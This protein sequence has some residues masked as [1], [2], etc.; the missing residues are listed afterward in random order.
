MRPSPLVLLLAALILLLV[1][2]TALSVRPPTGGLP[3]LSVQSSEPGGGR[4]LALWLEALGYRVDELDTEPYAVDPGVGALFVL[5][6]QTPFDEAAVD[7]VAAWVEGGGRLV[8]VTV[9]GQRALLERFGLRVRFAGD[10]LAEATTAQPLL[11]Q[12]PVERI[13]VDTWDFVEGQDG[14]APWLVAGDRVVLGSRPYG[15][16]QVIVLTALRP[17]SN[18]GLAEPESAALALNLVG[19]IPPG[20][21]VAFDEYHHGFVRGST[22]GLWQ[23]LLANYWGWAVIYAVALSYLYLWLRGRRF[24]P[25][26]GATTAARRSVSEYVASL[27]ALY[28]RAGQRGYVADRL[29]DQLKRDL[30]TGLGLNARLPDEA[31]AQ[32]VA[33][34]RATTPAAL[35][36]AFARLRAGG[37]LAERDLLALV[38]ETDALRA[39]LLRRAG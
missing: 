20:A 6:P 11:G 9:G 14:L 36:D 23:L 8:L 16:G 29:A 2:L 27:G 30:A 26:L 3:P 4:V 15:Q 32:A 13:R 25:P 12:P 1:I 21:R 39:R 7:A 17:L 34:R 5:A 10:R 33:D 35:A 38:R 19:R 18:E 31:F 22:R 28:R 37:R 24:G